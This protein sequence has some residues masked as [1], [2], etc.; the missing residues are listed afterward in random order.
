[1]ESELRRLRKQ[2]VAGATF[3]NEDFEL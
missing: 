1:M 2:E 3:G